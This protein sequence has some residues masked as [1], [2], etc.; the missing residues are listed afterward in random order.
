MLRLD[1]GA[2]R[3]LGLDSPR[4]LFL[5][6]IMRCRIDAFDELKNHYYRDMGATEVVDLNA[7]Q[8]VVGRVPVGIAGVGRGSRWAVIDRSGPLAQATFS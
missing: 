8:C 6:E 7:I 4:A 3:K 1:A 5:A 2:A